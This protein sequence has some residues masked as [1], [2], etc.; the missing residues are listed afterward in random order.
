MSY[1]NRFTGN[2]WESIEKFSYD[3]W[4]IS[5]VDPIKCTCI[6]HDTKQ[7]SNSCNKCFGLGT[8]VKIY[9]TKGVLREGRE[10][11]AVFTD[12]KLSTTPKMS[13]FKYN[14]I[15]VNNGDYIIDKEDIYSVVTK[16]YL[17]GEDGQ[18]NTVKLVCPSLKMDS[19]I[20]LKNFK[21]VLA[22]HGYTI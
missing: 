4:V 2:I 14:T 22:K 10:Q 18:P 6:D 5:K 9:K 8:K 12:T 3:V 16:Q 21:E 17:R 7:P 20:I 11:E 1:P 13:Y 19:K 15:F